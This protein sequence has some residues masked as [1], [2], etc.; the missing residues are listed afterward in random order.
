MYSM[1]PSLTIEMTH[2][3]TIYLSHSS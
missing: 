1:K 3:I 2:F